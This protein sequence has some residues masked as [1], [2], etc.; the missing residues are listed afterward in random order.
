M[1]PMT[2]APRP[3]TPSTVPAE[4]ADAGGQI[5]VNRA[6]AAELD[7]LPGIGPVIAQRIVDYRAENGPFAS[8]D[9]LVDIQGISAR[10]VEELRPLVTVGS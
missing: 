9:A 2:S 1:T 6:T 10:M 8:V 5:D 3:E 4:A 7:A